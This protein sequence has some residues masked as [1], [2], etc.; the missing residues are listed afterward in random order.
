M[1]CF[2]FWYFLKQNPSKSI[3]SHT[4]RATLLRKKLN[5]TTFLYAPLRS[6]YIPR[7]FLKFCSKVRR[8][9]TFHATLSQ[10]S[11]FCPRITRSYT[12][13]AALSRRIVLSPETY[14]F[15][16]VPI[17][18]PLKTRGFVPNL[19][20]PIYSVQPACEGHQTGSRAD[21]PPGLKIACPITFLCVL[22][23]F[24]YVPW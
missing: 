18:P 11:S 1:S 20:V 9:Y 23:A 17:N 2:L 4:V 7:F 13:H 12:F 19:R 14:T 16:Y 6:G 5:S 24:L 3:R 21:P 8:S 15:L 10:R 22:D